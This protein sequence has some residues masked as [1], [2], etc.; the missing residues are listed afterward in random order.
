MVRERRQLLGGLGGLGGLAG[1]GSSSYAGSVSKSTG[2]GISVLGIPLVGVDGN[3]NEAVAASQ[4]HSGGIQRIRR[5]LP[6]VLGG[7]IGGGSQSAS[8]AVSKS[9]GA[10][11]SILGVPLIGVG[12]NYN[13]A[14]SASQSHSGGIAGFWICKQVP[15]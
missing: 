10:G 6:G 9:T 8:A 5:Q 15:E 2:A 14:A 11:I 4:S 7:L 13:E 12:G 1:G 3:Y